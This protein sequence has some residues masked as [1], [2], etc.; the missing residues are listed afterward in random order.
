MSIYYCKCRNKRNQKYTSGVILIEIP[1]TNYITFQQFML[2]TECCSVIFFAWQIKKKVL[3]RKYLQLHTT[4][5]YRYV[6][7][8]VTLMHIMQYEYLFTKLSQVLMLQLWHL[9]FIQVSVMKS[10]Y[11]IFYLNVNMEWL[12]KILHA[13]KFT[14][15]KQWINLE[16]ILL[17]HHWQLIKW[18]ITE[19]TDMSTHNT[20]LF[21]SIQQDVLILGCDAFLMNQ[22]IIHYIT[23]AMNLQ[24]LNTEQGLCRIKKCSQVGKTDKLSTILCRGFVTRGTNLPHFQVSLYW[25]CGF[26]HTKWCTATSISEFH[27]RKVA[28][29][30]L[31]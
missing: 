10:N 14:V 25:A 20:M 27:T 28:T 18:C 4:Q 23:F 30:S 31:K 19:I 7:A 6:F 12:I 26:F 13:V 11:V 21:I 24:V 16:H 29:L 5:V 2:L 9:S 1:T 15:N 22:N 3:Q 8:L 17:V